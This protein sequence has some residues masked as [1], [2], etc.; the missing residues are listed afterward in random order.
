[1]LSGFIIKLLPRPYH[2]ILQ[3]WA[4]YFL[5]K[6]SFSL[7]LI[8]IYLTRMLIIFGVIYCERNSLSISE[9]CQ[10]LGK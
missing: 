9:P 7:I 10:M 6:S 4:K 2:K 3:T 1:M 5:L 8:N